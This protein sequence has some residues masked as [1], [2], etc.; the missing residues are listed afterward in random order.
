MAQAQYTPKDVIGGL[1]P[2]KARIPRHYAEYVEYKGDP[3]LLMAKLKESSID[4]MP[5]STAML[6]KVFI[7]RVG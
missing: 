2:R 5:A 3:G 7:R 4:C 6:N 1:A